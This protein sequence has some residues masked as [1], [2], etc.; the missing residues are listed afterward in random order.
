MSSTREERTF[1][2][3]A[4]S[5]GLVH[6]P[7][8]V[9]LQSELDV[10][11]YK[12]DEDKRDGELGLFKKALEATR[13]QITELRN[14]VARKLGEIEAQ[15][16]DAHLMVLEDKALIQETIDDFKHTH[17]NIAY[18][19]HKVSKRYIE[20]FDNFDDEY[21]RERAVDIRDVSKRVLGHLLGCDEHAP[22]RLENPRI[23]VAQDLTPSH[24]ASIE[25]NVVLGIVTDAGSRTSHAVI[26]ARSLQ[27]PAVV[28]LHNLSQSVRPGDF[29]FVDG[30]EGIVILNPSEATLEKYGQIKKHHD[31]IQKVF[32]SARKA[33]TE[34]KD[35]K[36]LELLLNV[37]GFEDFQEL[38]K[39]RS[40]GIGLFR[41]ETLFLKSSHL[42]SE[43]EQFEVYKNAAE[44]MNPSPVTIRTLDLGGDK[45]ASTSMF[46]NEET[47][48]F[49]GFR[50]IRLCLEHKQLFKDQ[51]KAILR[52]SAFGDIHIMYPMVGATWELLQANEILEECKEELRLAKIAFNENIPVGCM[53]E[54]PAA[55]MDCDAI[56][57]H[58]SFLSIGTNDLIQYMLAV[59]RVNDKI[60]HLYDPNHPGVLKVI[61]H[62]IDV[63]QKHGIPV[64]ICGEMAGEAI[65]APLLFGMGASSL[66]LTASTLPEV[67]YFM[68]KVSLAECKKLAK[69]ILMQ[70][71][72]LESLKILRLF[73]A[74]HMQ[75][76]CEQSGT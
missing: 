48:P 2:G 32:D 37:E 59:D 19:F 3:I 47:N 56:A 1:R 28:G 67:K 38:A 40:D 76:V 58:C 43:D 22:I 51:L 25:K 39:K 8:F 34:T 7:A 17:N 68:S 27:V 53:I 50:A 62:V 5:P 54:I 31:R 52:A 10:P 72:S 29:I 9:F 70:I 14:D 69:E 12:I 15:I 46:T 45:V 30:Y 11:L 71:D 23:L 4:A 57:Q 60:A 73:Y 6:G 21:M 13:Q 64:S 44:G 61:K 18:C 49:M 41:T 66:S 74:E 26:M 42:P 16:F 24:T 35:H 20:A 33:P 75:E 36:S 55:A 65:Y 63:G